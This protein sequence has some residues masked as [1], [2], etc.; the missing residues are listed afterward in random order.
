MRSTPACHDALAHHVST[1]RDRLVCSAALHPGYRL[2]DHLMRPATVEVTGPAPPARNPRGS[3]RELDFTAADLRRLSLG[4]EPMRV[5]ACR[6]TGGSATRETGT[7][8][9]RVL[10]AGSGD[11]LVRP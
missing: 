2:G 8:D 9:M 10:T 6:R 7:P 4:G 1:D 11:V 3:D 5:R